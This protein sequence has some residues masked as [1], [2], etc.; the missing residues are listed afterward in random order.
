MSTH[1]ELAKR[2]V[3]TWYTMTPETAREWFTEDAVY[4][5]RSDSGV[6]V[7]GPDEIYALLDA[8]R[9]ACARFENKL[10]NIAQ[11]GDV[12][13]LERDEVTYLKDGQSVAVPVMTSI[14]ICDGK[15]ALWRDYWDLAIITNLLMAGEMGE[16]ANQVFDRYQ[17]AASDRGASL[18][19]LKY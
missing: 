12:V 3:L 18:Q 19:Q 9:N 5:S 13:L 10:L 6:A 8:Y 14:L 15:I 17:D 2:C 7:T 11:D 1:K 16:Q 4:E